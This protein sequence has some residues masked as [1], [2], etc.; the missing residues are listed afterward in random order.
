M[1]KGMIIG[2]IVAVLGIGGS[3]AYFVT[4]NNGE[5]SGS[6]TTA[7]EDEQSAESGDAPTFDPAATSGQDFVATMNGTTTEGEEF[8]GEIE[9]DSNGSTH[10]TGTTAGEQVE[11]YTTANR[12]V[13]CTAG[14]CF[15]YGDQSS[16]PSTPDYNYNEEDFSDFR[17]TANYQGRQSCPAGTCNVWEITEDGTTTTVFI[18]DDQTVSQAKTSG[19]GGEFTITYEYRDVNIS[20][21]QNVQSVPTQ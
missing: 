10:F 16:L 13:L 1:S 18:T 17:D 11:F 6:Q 7:Q 9:Y 2:I 21:P 20:L 5:E 19:T 8:N 12:Y 14:N 15:E 3:V 4:R